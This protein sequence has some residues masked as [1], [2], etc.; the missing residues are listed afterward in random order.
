MTLRALGVQLLALV[1][2]A[3]RG[4]AARV[5]SAP[6]GLESYSV[7][8]VRLLSIAYLAAGLARTDLDP[9][10][11]RALEGRVQPAATLALVRAVSASRERGAS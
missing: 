6:A 4:A 10:V 3:A 1:L 9:V 11:A 7:E 2:D 8:D 5:L